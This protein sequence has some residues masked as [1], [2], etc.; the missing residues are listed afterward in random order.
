M[1]RIIVALCQM[2]LLAVSPSTG[3]DLK[4]LFIVNLFKLQIFSIPFLEVNWIW[5]MMNV[6]LL[7]NLSDLVLTTNSSY[8]LVP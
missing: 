7:Y 8:C 1:V 4:L 6:I 5:R 2:D 3:A